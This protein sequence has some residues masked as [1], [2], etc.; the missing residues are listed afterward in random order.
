MILVFTVAFQLTGIIQDMVDGQ[1]NLTEVLE[2]SCLLHTTYNFKQTSNKLFRI[3]LNNF[4]ANVLLIFS[5]VS[6]LDGRGGSFKR[7]Y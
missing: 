6:L 7:R 5:E 1:P 3:F 2:V 4:T